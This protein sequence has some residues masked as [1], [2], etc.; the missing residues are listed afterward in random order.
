M[1]GG[2][3]DRLV[4]LR[5][6]IFGTKAPESKQDSAAVHPET[7]GVRSPVD[8]TISVSVNRETAKTDPVSK[9]SK[10]TAPEQ[11]SPVAKASTTRA[12]R[13]VSTK[14]AK[15]APKKQDPVQPRSLRPVAINLGID[16]GTSFTKVCYRDVGTE[17]SG[18]VAVG[19]ADAL[20]D[21]VVVVSR[22]GKL[23]LTDAA[24][25]LKASIRVPYLKMRLAGVPIGDSLPPV[26]GIELSS[27]AAT[28]ALAAWFLA[29]VIARSQAWMAANQADR[30][31]GRAAIWSANV[32]VPVEHYDSPILKTFEEVLGVAWLWVR[33]ETIPETLQEALDAYE[34]GAGRLDTEVSDF[35]AV[36]EIA[37]AVQSFVMSREAQEGIYVYFDIGGGGA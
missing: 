1:S 10:T 31:K 19:T 7:E 6:R 2:W 34:A 18:V 11:G 29:S 13:G 32:G 28:K 23:Y 14:A 33:H 3:R 25:S 4:T 35:H 16:F 9:P 27:E 21:S 20:L 8:A 36:A 5:N 26:R 37:A 12:V 15:P 30:L 17:E 24:K 22:T